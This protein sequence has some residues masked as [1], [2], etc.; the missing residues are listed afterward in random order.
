MAATVG[1]V[2]D[3]VRA[4]AP[5]AAMTAQ[6]LVHVR[7]DSA[8]H[9]ANVA[10]LKANAHHKAKAAAALHRVRCLNNAAP[11]MPQPLLAP[12]AAS[13]TPMACV[14]HPPVASLT[15]CAPA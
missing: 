2:V 12:P 5:H 8:H 3:V 4:A 10:P 15:P 14:P 7:T 6:S 11:T 1:A 13:A 9:R